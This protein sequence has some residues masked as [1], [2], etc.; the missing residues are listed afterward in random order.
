MAVADLGRT[1]MQ[2]RLAGCMEFSFDV[3]GD[4]LQEGILLFFM[5]FHEVSML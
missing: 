2:M 5:T 3:R 1:D 4:F